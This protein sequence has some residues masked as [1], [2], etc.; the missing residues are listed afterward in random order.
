MLFIIFDRC[1]MQCA[2]HLLTLCWWWELT[3]KYHT[4]KFGVQYIDVLNQYSMHVNISRNASSL[5][6]FLQVSVTWFSL[7]TVI[8]V[9]CVYTLCGWRA[10][11]LR[12]QFVSVGS[13][14]VLIHAGILV[15]CFPL[16]SCLLH[17]LLE[18]LIVPHHI[19]LK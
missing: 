19:G 16:S 2:V 12:Y 10:L 1:L 8:F 3:L 14:C 4:L 18:S 5:S 7:I 15:N 9:R 6:S 17:L 11:K 13:R